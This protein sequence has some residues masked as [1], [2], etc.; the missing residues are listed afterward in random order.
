MQNDLEEKHAQNGVRESEGE[1]QQK[2]VAEDRHDNAHGVD[3][4][5]AALGEEKDVEQRA[6]TQ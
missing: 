1:Q 5:A 3:K 4:V 6:R 2:H